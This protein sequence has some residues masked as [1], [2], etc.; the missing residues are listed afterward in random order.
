MEETKME[1]RDV[2]FTDER[3]LFGSRDL[4]LNGCVF[5]NGESPLKESR[6][7]R[8]TEQVKKYIVSIV[9]ATR[10]DRNATLGICD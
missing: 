6:D 1:Y 7:I 3:S 8:V 4:D 10:D 5:E 2:K 9:S